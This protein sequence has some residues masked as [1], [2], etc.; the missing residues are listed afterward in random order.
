[1]TKSYDE[2][3][4]IYSE[5]KRF[6]IFNKTHFSPQDFNTPDSA[7]FLMILRSYKAYLPQEVM[8]PGVS[9]KRIDVT[10]DIEVFYFL[11]L[12]EKIQEEFYIRKNLEENL[13][14]EISQ[15][16]FVKLQNQYFSHLACNYSVNLHGAIP[17]KFYK[18]EFEEPLATELIMETDQQFIFINWYSTA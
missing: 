9:L 13:I 18:V 6:L 7:E 15:E 11:V 12:M 2:L 8:K 4:K 17:I 1:M 3:I 5:N 14:K 16:E 10:H